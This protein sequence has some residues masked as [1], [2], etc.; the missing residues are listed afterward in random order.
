MLY[1]GAIRFLKTALVKLEKKDLEQTHVHIVKAKD[2]VSELMASLKVEQAGEIGQNLHRLYGYIFNRLID[3]NIQKN[4]AF[5][6]ESIELLDE[7]RLG[8]QGLINQRKNQVIPQT[9]SEAKTVKV[10]G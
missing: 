10:E 6:E 1:D 4:Q 8:W 5:I 2:I 9:R 7:L 3:A